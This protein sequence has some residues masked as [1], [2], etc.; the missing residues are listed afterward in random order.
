MINT[1]TA[2]MNN[3]YVYVLPGSNPDCR[4]GSQMIFHLLDSGSQSSYTASK[5][6]R[7]YGV[8][9]ANMRW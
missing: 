3:R 4:K 6:D 1:S 7:N 2:V 8:P 5:T 9:M